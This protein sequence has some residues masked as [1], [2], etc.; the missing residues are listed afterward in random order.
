[1]KRYQLIYNEIKTSI[2]KNIYPPNTTLPSE[3]KF[4]KDYQVSRETIRKALTLLAEDGY[5]QKQQGKPSIVLDHKYFEFP[6]SN[7]T[8]YLELDKK[9]QLHSKTIVES[10]DKKPAKIKHHLYPFANKEV[11]QSIRT[12]KINGEKIILDKDYLNPKIIPNITNKI[13]EN[14]LFEYVEQD[15]GLIIDYS[16]K[17]IT[18]EPITSEDRQYLDLSPKDNCIV[19]VRSQSFLKDTTLFEYTESRHRADKFIFK[20][21][22]RRTK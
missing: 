14:S 19:V 20:E 18:V 12:R 15:L 11:W 10:L 17:E 9:Q 3:C 2:E 22:A 1:M 4:A 21:F 6:V 5:I 7:L 8:S 13:L 16:I